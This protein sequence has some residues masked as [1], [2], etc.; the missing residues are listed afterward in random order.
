MTFSNLLGNDQAKSLL[1]KLAL[2]ERDSHILLFSGTQDVGK[3]SFV[4][5]F[6]SLLLGEK[7]A[8]KIQELIH[9]DVIWLKPEGKLHLHQIASIKQMIDEAPLFPFEAKKKIYVIE[10]ADRMLP[11]SSNTLLKMLEEPPSHICCI[12]LT[13]HEEAILPTLLSRC[14]RIPFYPI[15]EDLIASALI[16]KGTS[17]EIVKKIAMTSKGSFSFALHLLTEEK[18]PIHLHFME[19]L[20]HFFL[21]K[22][23]LGMIEALDYLEKLID[24]KTEEEGGASLLAE[25]LLDDVLFWIRDL[26]CKKEDPSGKHLF[27]E[28]C[29]LDLDRQLQYKIPSLETGLLLID[30]A[31]LALQRSVKPKVVFENLFMQIADLSW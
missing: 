12:L 15:G 13:S 9:P 1:A 11:T 16:E 23:S 25:K 18:N 30:K 22:P 14:S 26:H 7:H 10:E 2:K 29:S 27:Y 31:R 8:K 4:I 17:P 21:Q 5:A 19:I 20:R 24:E 6:L 3:K 28:G